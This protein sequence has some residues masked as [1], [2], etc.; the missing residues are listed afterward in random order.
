MSWSFLKTGTRD[1]V[2]DQVDE[3]YDN[4]DAFPELARDAIAAQL[5]EL[6]DDASVSLTTWGHAEVGDDTA[7][8]TVSCHFDLTWTAVPEAADDGTDPDE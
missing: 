1:E 2:A 5:E 8:G 6:P 3:E 4:D 7:G